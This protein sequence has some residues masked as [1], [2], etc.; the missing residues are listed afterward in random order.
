MLFLSLFLFFFIFLLNF[1]MLIQLHELLL[2]VLKFPDSVAVAMVTMFLE[3]PK[4]V[5]FSR[6][7]LKRHLN[8]LFI[9]SSVAIVV[10][11][12]KNVLLLMLYYNLAHGPAQ[13]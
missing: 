2:T 13:E 6:H 9:K 8:T 11:T 12:L 10:L 4:T 5:N 1:F 3:S 7:S